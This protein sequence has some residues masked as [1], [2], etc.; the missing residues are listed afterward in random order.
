[1]IRKTL[2]TIITCLLSFAS[3]SQVMDYG[4]PIMGRPFKMGKDMQIEGSPLLFNEWRTGKVILADKRVVND[5]KLKFELVQNKF[6][7]GRND[8]LFEFVDE[9]QEIRLHNPAY[10]GDPAY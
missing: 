8:S 4:N 10:P 3:F 2:A 7:Y 9:V 6:F 5:M 1:M